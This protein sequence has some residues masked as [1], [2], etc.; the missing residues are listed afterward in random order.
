MNE[1]NGYIFVKFK[2][3]NDMARCYKILILIESWLFGF[4]NMFVNVYYGVFRN[5][6]YILSF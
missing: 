4:W 6:D 1:G 3:R 5:D 2:L